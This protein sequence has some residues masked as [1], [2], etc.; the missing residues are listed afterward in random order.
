MPNDT[1]IDNELPIDTDPI[2]PKDVPTKE[3]I[4][5]K[6]DA[7]LDDII[8]VPTSTA[9]DVQKFSE[10]LEDIPL[11]LDSGKQE[12]RRA[13][14]VLHYRWCTQY[15]LDAIDYAEKKSDLTLSDNAIAFWKDTHTFILS[16]LRTGT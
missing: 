13:D 15:T 16:D 1:P 11:W 5:T 8:A 3:Q 2:D 4:A 12:P 10:K 6:A 7:L 9:E 14:K